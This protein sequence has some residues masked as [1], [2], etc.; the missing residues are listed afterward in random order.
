[1]SDPLQILA[2]PSGP[3]KISGV[4][5]LEFCGEPLDASGD[6][7]L[8]RCGESSNMPFCDGSH[9]AA[10]FT[11]A[12]EA[13]EAKEVRVWE[14]RTIQTFFNPNVCMHVFT[15]KPL[16]ELREAELGGDD[17]AA[18]EIARV[19][20]ACPSGALRWEAP[21]E[22]RA[23]AP[24]REG[25]RVEIM[26]GGEVRILGAYACENFDLMEGMDGERATLCRCGRSKNKPWCDGRH[27]G[28]KGFR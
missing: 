25:G 15:C 14:G 22:T 10:G 12:C 26:E 3:L 6:V 9:K 16:K 4:A 28:R 7:Y 20:D 2:I 1:M 18:E 19:V 23:T 11:G 24:V 5:Q 17:A 21:T 27:K 13:G 8:C